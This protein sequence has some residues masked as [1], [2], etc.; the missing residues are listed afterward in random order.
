MKKLMLMQ[1]LLIT[2]LNAASILAQNV[3]YPLSDYMM[4]RDAEMTLA[5]S[6]AP[7]PSST[8][9]GRRAGPWRPH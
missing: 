8:R 6:A 7:A 9:R 1:V 4:P 3:K 2:G 5:R